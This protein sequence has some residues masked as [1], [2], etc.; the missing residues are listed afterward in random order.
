M[1]GVPVVGDGIGVH[2]CA[3][4]LERRPIRVLLTRYAQ[5]L[6]TMR[7]G[8]RPF[9]PF[10]YRQMRRRVEAVEAGG[11]DLEGDAH[12]PDDEDEIRELRRVRDAIDNG[13]IDTDGYQPQCRLFA[14]VEDTQRSAP[15][16][17][18]L[19]VADDFDE[20]RDGA[21]GMK[22]KNMLFKC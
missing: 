7:M 17:R 20:G 12:G 18:D 11:D 4:I 15:S 21:T 22:R 9:D 1:E 8:P 19:V 6:R 16:Q 13:R 10:K 3:S 5:R 2:R 14:S